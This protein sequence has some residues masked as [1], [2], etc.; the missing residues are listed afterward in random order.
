MTRP[1]ILISSL[2]L[3]VT[4]RG[5]IEM[6]NTF[7]ISSIANVILR[8]SGKATVM[9]RTA[10][11]MPANWPQHDCT[12]PRILGRGEPAEKLLERG[13]ELSF[14]DDSVSSGI[15]SNLKSTLKFQTYLP[16]LR[17]LQPVRPFLFQRI[18]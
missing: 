8:F 2:E 5:S 14:A 17:F 3:R 15:V 10:N 7:T 4:T 6:Q 1:T 11:A 12:G 18:S 9:F 13:M 16:S